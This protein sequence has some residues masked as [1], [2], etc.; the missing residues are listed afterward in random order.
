MDILPIADSQ[1]D[2]TA[3]NR[4]VDRL[5]FRVVEVVPEV[6]NRSGDHIGIETETAIGQAQHKEIKFLRPIRIRPA[7]SI[8]YE[9]VAKWGSESQCQFVFVRPIRGHFDVWSGWAVT[10]QGEGSEMLAF[11]SVKT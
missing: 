3:V 9:T 6:F 11:I 4:D 5:P 8:G 7:T 1:S 10:R 2:G